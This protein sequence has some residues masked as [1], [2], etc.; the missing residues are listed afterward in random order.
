V[1]GIPLY[2]HVLWVLYDYSH[3]YTA[4]I[5]EEFKVSNPPTPLFQRGRVIW[6]SKATD[7]ERQV[8]MAF[9]LALYAQAPIASLFL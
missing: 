6:L 2:G 7:K 5:Q 8:S 9:N 1:T 4:E 3:S